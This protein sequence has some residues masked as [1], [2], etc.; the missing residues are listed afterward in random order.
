ML[1]SK[2]DLTSKRTLVTGASSGIG[3]EV[4]RELAGLGALV[5][6]SGRDEERLG[7]V[8]GDIDSN[9]GSAVTVPADL[10]LDDGPASLVRDTIEALGGLDILVPSAGIF[11]PQPFERI[12]TRD[13]DR[14][15]EINVR[16]PFR[17]LQA[18]LPFLEDGG[19]VV[20][21]ISSIA[22]HVGFANDSSYA[23]TKSA[24]DGLTR[25]LSVELA[26]RGI[27]I[28][29]VAPGFTESPMNAGYRRNDVTLTDR[30]VSCT[31]AGR[32]GQP[33]DVAAA[34]AYL[35]SDAANYIHGAI[36]PVD[37]NYPTSSIQ[38]GLA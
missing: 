28:N 19:G 2:L 36:L 8:A 38:L 10:V 17:L 32:L 12:S 6:L 4:A 3:A 16:A 5:A 11:E 23:A 33:T 29:A 21:F 14:V 25:A 22:G 20:V 7:A 35:A 24:I 27:R 13:F 1:K 26:P 15:W 37:G 31:P 34:V 18:A 9:G 30:A